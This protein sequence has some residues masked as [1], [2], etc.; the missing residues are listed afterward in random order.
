MYE[1]EGKG[2]STPGANEPGCHMTIL[3]STLSYY[4]FLL[5]LTELYV[6]E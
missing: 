3:T 4:Y 2:V 5:E 1:D 6:T